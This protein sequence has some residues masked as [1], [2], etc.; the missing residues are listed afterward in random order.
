MATPAS[1]SE[2]L[3]MILDGLGYL[4][5]TDPAAAATES[6]AECLRALERAGAV[7]TA[8]RARY[9]G[10]FTAGQGYCAD[11]D[12]SPT[13][14]L[15]N[16]TGV[17]KGAARAYLGW[18]RRSLAHPGVD[19]ALAEGTVLTESMAQL[20][21]QWT[22]RLPES[23][24]DAADDI[25]VAAAR[26]GARQ[27]DLAALAAEMYARSRSDTDD[28]DPGMVFE[29]R[30]VRVETTFDGAGVITGDLTPECAAVVTAVLDSLSAPVGAQDTRTKEQRYHDALAEAMRRLVASGMLPERAGQPVK[31]WAHVSLAELRALDD[32]S[33]LQDQWITEMAVRWAARRAAAADGSGSDGG[34]WLDGPA[35]RAVACDATLTPVVT[36]DVDPG[37]LDHLVRLCVELDRLEHRTSPADGSEP[38]GGTRSAAAGLTAAGLARCGGMLSRPARRPGRAC[39]RPSSAR[40]SSCCPVRAGWP[41]SCAPGSWEPGWPGRACRWTSGT[42]RR[43]R[44]ASATRS[45][46]GTGAAAGP[47]AATSPRRPARSTTSGTWPT[48]GRPA[49]P[50]A[51]CCAPST[52]RW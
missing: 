48:A 50:T 16:R 22:D 27:E 7:S 9:L 45:S 14:W 1:T 36:G 28:D 20:I 11:A 3:E 40:P 39:G 2:A 46:C 37:A 49:W 34:A 18:A 10:A 12:Y 44:R 23:C 38:D 15:I 19:A 29:D 33:V 35:A 4:A 30:Q 32:G 13:G 6:Q 17:T 26:A 31:A 8:V 47:A 43:S 42:A 5:A 41:V 52:T 21:C 24:R 25:L 51:C